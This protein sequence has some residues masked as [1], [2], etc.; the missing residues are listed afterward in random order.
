MNYFHL[1]NETQSIEKTI[2]ELKKK[3][4]VTQK[5]RKNKLKESTTVKNRINLL[6]KEETKTWKKIEVVRNKTTDKM[7]LIDHKH[8]NIE[9]KIKMENKKETE[10][11][12]NYIKVKTIREVRKKTFEE[13]S[14][15][16]KEKSCATLIK[17]ERLNRENIKKS[18]SQQDLKYKT[19]LF[20]S[21]KQM[22]FE[23][24]E[25]KKA[26]ENEN[27]NNKK[28]RL[29]EKL[30]KVTNDIKE[31]SDKISLFENEE[32]DILKRMQKSTV[33]LSSSKINYII[34]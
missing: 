26:R 19:N 32:L 8:N 24:I 34:I 14:N 9:F 31:N 12:K 15:L 6:N 16:F 18:N 3:L 27:N 7:N 29:E 25:A 1:E 2:F 21:I 11:N 30:E 23:Q 5:E 22:E 13:R 28:R 20:K 33:L 4:K 10:Y 17:T